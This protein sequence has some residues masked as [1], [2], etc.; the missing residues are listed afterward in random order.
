MPFIINSFVWHR[1][2]LNSLQENR[3]QS[4]SSQLFPDSQLKKNGWYETTIS[5]F[6]GHPQNSRFT[7]IL[8]VLCSTYSAKFRQFLQTGVFQQFKI[9]LQR[10]REE[11]VYVKPVYF[12]ASALSLLSIGDSPVSW[13]SLHLPTGTLVIE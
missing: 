6:D 4:T 13:V 12:M 8:M 9:N 11:I 7:L 2:N 3:I 10:Q 5:T 1:L